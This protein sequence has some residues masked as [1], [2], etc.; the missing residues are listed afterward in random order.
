VVSR[1]FAEPDEPGT[2]EFGGGDRCGRKR[3]YGDSGRPACRGRAP[4]GWR[5]PASREVTS[6][7]DARRRRRANM[8]S[9]AGTAEPPTDRVQ[10]EKTS[11]RSCVMAATPAWRSPKPRER[12]GFPG[13]NTQPRQSSM[14]PARAKKPKGSEGRSSVSNLDTKEGNRVTHVTRLEMARGAGSRGPGEP[15]ARG[16]RARCTKSPKQHREQ[17]PGP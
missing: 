16:P 13:S 17:A 14:F 1:Q 3:R 12:Y 9:G 6:G 8:A 7:M 4:S 10:T 2:Q 5:S 15:D 11:A